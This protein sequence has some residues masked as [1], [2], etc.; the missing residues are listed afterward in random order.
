[1]GRGRLL[2][3]PYGVG[4]EDEDGLPLPITLAQRRHDAQRAR[5]EGDTRVITA[6]RVAHTFGQ[7]PV[8]YLEERRPLARLIRIAAHN[9]IIRDENARNGR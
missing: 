5:L 9:I 6:A 7:D 3:G 2:V 4:D 8:A 1:M